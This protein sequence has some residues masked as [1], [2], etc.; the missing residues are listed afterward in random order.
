M[1][2]LKII[3]NYNKFALG[4]C[5]FCM[6][7]T[8]VLCNATIQPG[9]PPHLKGTNSGWVTAEYFMLPQSSSQQR[10]P[11]QQQLT[12]GRT[13]EISRIIGRA[14]RAVVNLEALGPNTVIIDC[15][16][17]QA[18][19]GTRTAAINGSFIAMYDLFRNLIKQQKLKENPIK[20]F[21][22]SVS[23]G[24]VNGKKV[25]DLNQQQ[26]NQAEVDA[27]VV[28]TEDKEIIE[29]QYTS[30]KGL[31]DVKLLNELI[32]LAQQSILKIIQ[33]EKKVLKR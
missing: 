30:E 33:L 12:S 13:K 10:N 14:L 5:L 19:G 1:R 7:N 28:M 16:V 11:R 22:G 20:K 6:G 4:S 9:Q 8:Q 31:Y 18:D 3:R 2:K 25:V 29:L 27:T 21:I 17:L 26:D 23:A 24:V 32:A 15:D